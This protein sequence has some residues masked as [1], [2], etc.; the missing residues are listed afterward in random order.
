M[1]KC[2][3]PVA[4]YCARFKRRMVGRLHDICQDKVLTPDKCAAYRSLWAEQVDD[5]AHIEPIPQPTGPNFAKRLFNFAKSATAHL[6]N[7]SPQCTEEQIAERFA[8]CEQC[9]LF[10][11]KVCTHSDCG[12]NVGHERKYLNLLAWAD[13]SCPDTPPRWKAIVGKGK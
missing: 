12:C 5:R 8:I 2:H 13:K 4:G 7:G 11:G 6:L 9:P 3:C 10:N 1:N